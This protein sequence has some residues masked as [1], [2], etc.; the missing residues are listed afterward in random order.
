MIEIREAKEEDRQSA[1]RVLWKAFESTETFD[2][3]LKQEWVKA[4]HRPENKDWSYVATDNGDVVANLSMFVTD[5]DVIRGNPIPFAG[6]WAVATMPHYRRKGLV[7]KLFD[8]A[9]PRMHDE[10]AVLSILDP[11]SRSFYEK[12]GYALAEKRA[13]YVFTKDDLRIGISDPNIT[14]REATLEDMERVHGVEQTMAR[15]GSRFFHMKHILKELL[16]SGHFLIFEEDGD[17]V[18]TCWFRFQKSKS[19]QGNDLIVAASSYIED[20]VFPSIV[21]QVRNYATNVKEISW[22]TDLDVPVRHYFS[23]IHS[24]QMLQIGSMMMRIVDFE[25]YCRSISIPVSASEPVVL[26]LEEGQ[27]PWN[28]GVYRIMPTSGTLEVE[29]TNELPDVTLS[30]YQLSAVISGISSA[31]LLHSLHEIECDRHCAEK[32]EAIFPNDVFVSYS[33]F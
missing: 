15:F 11:F 17:V 7:R 32:L 25:G 27:C 10:G 4:W 26:K 16:E 22:Y 14:C 1:I 6:V 31:T 20:R 29:R 28:G 21:E 33:R 5:D 19:G 8:A 18:G 23:G 30:P 13:K 9:Y 2:N 12:F 24:S 3:V